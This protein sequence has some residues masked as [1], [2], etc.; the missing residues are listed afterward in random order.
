MKLVFVSDVH[1]KW[2]KIIIPECDILFSCGDYSFRGEPEVVKNYHE[3]L[4]EQPAKHIV[5]IN[6][7]HELWVEKNF[8]EAKDIALKACPIVQFIQHEAIE[9]EGLKI[10]GSA[11]TPYFNDWAYNAGRT[12]TEAAYLRKPF[13]GDL[14]Q[15]IPLDTQILITHGPGVGT[16]DWVANYM[17]GKIINV[18]CN[19]LTKKIVEL[20]D[21]KIH[22]FGHLHMK[23]GNVMEQDGVKY[24]NA[25]VCDDN[26]VAHNDRIIVIDF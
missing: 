15:D 22:A 8:N 9:I 4:D 12:I 13:I 17:S 18:G 26:Y 14:W 16:L 2:N 3:W 23:G 5:S 19:E 21:L 20:K 25:S 6:G 1:C 10:F 24:I 7:N 11:W